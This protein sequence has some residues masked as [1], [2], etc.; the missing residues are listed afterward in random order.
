MCRWRSY[1]AASGASSRTRL[2]CTRRYKVSVERAEQEHSVEMSAKSS[3]AAS[4]LVQ[5]EELSGAT[6]TTL[7]ELRDA[8][9][10]LLE[11]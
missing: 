9:N 3:S 10:D 5:G 2:H 7:R 8:L 6:L 1:G 11:G 4:G